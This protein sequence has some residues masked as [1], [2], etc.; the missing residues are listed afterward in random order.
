MLCVDVAGNDRAG[1]CAGL[2]VL[3]NPQVQYLG[4]TSEVAREGCLS[5]PDLTAEVA[6]MTEIAITGTVPGTGEQRC[7]VASGFEARALQHEI[8]HLDGKLIVD[9]VTNARGLHPRRRYR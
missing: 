3:A 6:R 2:V 5:V 9:R 4:A 1:S 8:D 7:I